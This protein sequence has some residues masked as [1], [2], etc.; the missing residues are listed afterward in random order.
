MDQLLNAWENRTIYIT[1]NDSSVVFSATFSGSFTD[2]L[3]SDIGS[4]VSPIDKLLDTEIQT[5]EIELKTELLAKPEAYSL[6]INKGNKGKII[7]T[8]CNARLYCDVELHVKQDC[9][10]MIWNILW[11]VTEQP[12]GEPPLGCPTV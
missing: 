6:A 12:I 4:V 8:V 1:K 11:M 10:L 5:I 2:T 7:N 3:F 9:A